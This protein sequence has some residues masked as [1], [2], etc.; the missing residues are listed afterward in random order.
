MCAQVHGVGLEVNGSHQ[1]ALNGASWALPCTGVLQVMWTDGPTC[2][3]LGRCSQSEGAAVS[4]AHRLGSVK[5]MACDGRSFGSAL[6]CFRT[7]LRGGGTPGPSAFLGPS[8]D[9]Q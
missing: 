4:K 8:H 6:H 9:S 5:A 1:G 2:K 3:A 7:V